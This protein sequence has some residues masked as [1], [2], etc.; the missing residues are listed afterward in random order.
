M[1]SGM[2]T[3]LA[4]SYRILILSKFSK[5]C[6]IAQKSVENDFDGIQTKWLKSSMQ[7]SRNSKIWHHMGFLMNREVNA[8]FG[9]QYATDL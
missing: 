6:G 5:R 4:A 7:T 8:Y 9:L 3:N 2:E 1:F